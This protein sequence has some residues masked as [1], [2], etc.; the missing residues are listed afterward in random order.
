M[1]QVEETFCNIALN[2]VETLIQNLAIARFADGV[3]FEIC[4]SKILLRVNHH[5]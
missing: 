3:S 1:D 2:H 5:E 4:S